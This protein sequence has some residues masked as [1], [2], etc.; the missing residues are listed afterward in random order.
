[1]APSDT[2][3]LVDVADVIIGMR[4]G[5]AFGAKGRSRSVKRL[6][7]KCRQIMERIPAATGYR[8]RR[9]GVISLSL[10][11]REMEQRWRELSLTVQGACVR[12]PFYARRQCSGARFG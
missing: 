1:M 3:R 9:D 7:S 4:F 6:T 5:L 8:A 2:Q 10:Q 11:R 12:C